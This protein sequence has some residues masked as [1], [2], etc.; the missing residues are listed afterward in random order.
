MKS[1]L[2]FLLSVTALVHAQ[3]N[4]DA[5]RYFLGAKG[6]LTTPQAGPM[7][8][9]A[10]E[11]VAAQSG[12][13]AKDLNSLYVEREYTDAHNGVTHIV[14]KQQ[15]QGMDVYNAAW[16][17]NLNA[18]GQVLN[19]G[20]EIF[21]APELAAP[22]ASSAEK[23]AR[24]AVKAVNPRLAENFR[25]VVSRRM[26][27][28]ATEARFT[29]EDRDVEGR[30][31]WYG[32]RGALVPAWV[33]N[34]T[35]EDGV[36]SYNMVVDDAT[37]LPLNKMATTH[38]QNANVK[39]LVY[40][41]GSPNPAPK[42]GVQITT[43]PPLVNRTSQPFAGDPIASPLGWVSS[44]ATSGN[45]AVVGQNLLGTPFL[46]DPT[47]SVAKDGDFNFPIQLGP[48]MPPTSG[49]ADAVNTNLFF[50]VNKA[51]DLHY[52]NGFT[53]ATGNFQ[54]ENF[55]R[56]GVGGDQIYAYTHYG[57]QALTRAATR[58]AFFSFR[59]RS[60]G[61]Q[62]MI[63]MYV[64]HTGS[65]GYYVDG[66]LD[67]VVVVHE[68][69]HGVSERLL[70]NG[71]S[72]FQEGS[73]GEAWSDFYGM[74]Y[75]LPE[76]APADGYY[77]TGEYFI[78][79]YGSG[80]RTRPYST[81]LAIDPLTYADLGSVISFPEVHA[82]GEIWM[83]AMW[84]IRAAF[85][86]Q[87]GEKEGRRRVRLLIIDGMK[88]M[89]PSSTMIDA[90]DA[91]LLAD[92]VDFKGESQ[93][94][95]W[96]AFA[97]R[98][99]GATA[100]SFS[101]N[102][103]HISSS[104]ELP[105]GKA[106]VVFHDSEITVGESIRVMVSDLN[107][108]ASS[109]N[110]QLTS[111]SGDVESIQLRRVGS[112]FVGSI[113][114]SSNI[115]IKESGTLNLMPGDFA[116]VYYTDFNTGSGGAE[117]F[118][119]TIPVRS[120]YFTSGVA[121]GFDIPATESLVFNG[122]FVSLPFEFR[123]FEK[124]YRGVFVDTNGLLHFSNAALYGC[125]DLLT[126]RT[127][128][129]IAPFWLQLSTSGT[130]Q[131]R[132]GIYTS[133]PNANSIRFRWVAETS[134]AFGVG[135]PVNFSATLVDDGSILFNYGSGNTDLANAFS[136]TGCL[137]RAGLPGGPTVG[138]SSGHDT[139]SLGT[140]VKSSWTNTTGFRFDP[141][142]GFSSFP[143]VTLES[144][145]ADE[146]VQDILTISGVAYDTDTF[147]SRVYAVI[148]GV[149]YGSTTA[150]LPRPDFCATQNVRGCPNVG[151]SMNILTN[152]LAP[153]KH[154]LQLR[155]LNGRGAFVDGPATPISFTVD[156]GQTRLPFGKLES[157]AA[158]TEVTGTLTVRGYAAINDLRVVAVDTIIDGLTYATTYNVARTDICGTL[159][160]VPLNCNN[161]G[162]QAAIN[163]R[164][165]TPPL[166]DG[167][168]T[169]VIRVRDELG[170]LTILPDS[171]VK[172]TV[173]NGATQLPI[174]AI[175]S[176]KSGDRLSGTVTLSGYAYSPAGAIRSVLVV[177]DS[178]FG[179]TSTL[180]GAR[181]EV[182]ANLKDVTAC[183]NIGWTMDFDTRRLANG[184]H[185]IFIQITDAAGGI[186]TTPLVGQGP[187]SVNV[188]N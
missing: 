145:K 116:S 29:S 76:G 148:D 33:F 63:A 18:A 88:F 163:T 5:R 65:G 106:K 11:Y 164:T 138:L 21:G 124:S 183:P 83:A 158:G 130:A 98:G 45:N 127:V 105:S 113:A 51:H 27:S 167:E 136:V 149:Q 50:W 104:T 44:N 125:N 8:E 157:P 87:F 177:Y 68:Y 15:F 117:Q 187:L 49:F 91:I 119:A 17:V 160:P 129:A 180:G 57:S 150:T 101:G 23:A 171:T 100:Y 84:E 75:T 67:A 66:A 3:S 109:V 97:K 14:Y 89:P 54:K 178:L 56:G 110:V 95:L 28:R 111:S 147:F 153:G 188:Q 46:P 62:P 174:G 115:V 132:E 172:F 102:T 103:V 82:D 80:I 92:R 12:V 179:I 141:P 152:N 85:I 170:R 39:G 38:F 112:V 139:Y 143:S 140:F 47:I 52:Q 161:I 165:G 126:L 7:R 156:A 86:K 70:P 135:T 25:P 31:V 36:S 181:P 2:I 72:T 9:I 94:Q 96:A 175:T 166:Q 37:G 144:P 42:P 48:G 22:L 79:K 61:S 71:S 118:T 185:I 162:F 107:N 155:G 26:P 32:M 186:S 10:R 154:T 13:D 121:A 1:F 128:P 73:M 131:P 69:T 16:V 74:E 55:G 151:F 184:N 41:Q 133:R 19:A 30:M 137:G 58:N 99:M 90:R 173:K 77:P 81:D 53:E 176:H 134:T 120:T 114:S 146:K 59:N 60:D 108:T 35:D 4:S 64:S 168:H 34:V 159:K 142:F 24:A 40:E 6:P 182:C 122:Q 20:G 93:S 43:T 78:G 123:F 169:L